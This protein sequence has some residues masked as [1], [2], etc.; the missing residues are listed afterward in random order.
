MHS[1]NYSVMKE[2]AMSDVK[3]VLNLR[4]SELDLIRETLRR[5][6]EDLLDWIA[7]RETSFADKAANRAEAIR[8]GD[9]LGKLDA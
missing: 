7:D 6:H 1:R 3:A 8:I 5:R 4:V 2:R 9:L